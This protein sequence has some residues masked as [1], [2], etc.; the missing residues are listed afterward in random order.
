MTFGILLCKRTSI[1]IIT[2][3]APFHLI[4]AILEWNSFPNAAAAIEEEE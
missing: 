3:S 1:I 2:I 4:F